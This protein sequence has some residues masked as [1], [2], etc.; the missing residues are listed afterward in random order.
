MGCNCGGSKSTQ[1]KF[2]YTAP[3]GSVTVYK[4]EIEAQAQVVRNGGSYA[5][6][7]G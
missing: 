6:I 7:Q 4:T 3:N 5:R 1:D 2:R